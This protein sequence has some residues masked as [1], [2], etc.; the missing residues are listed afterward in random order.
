MTITLKVGSVNYEGWKTANVSRG[1]GYVASDFD[2]T[3]TEKWAD[4]FEIFPIKTG[5]SVSVLVNGHQVMTGH[6]D[7]VAPQY[8]SESHNLSIKGRSKTADLVDCSVTNLSAIKGQTISQVAKTLA[9]PFGLSVTANTNSERSFDEDIQQDET[10]SEVLIELAKME[11]FLIYDSADGGLIISRSGTK[12]S[13]SKLFNGPE[14]SNVLSGGS[15]ESMRDRYSEYT[16][17]GQNKGT[18]TS[19]GTSASEPSAT[20]YDR[21]VPRYRPLVITAD[22]AADT[23]YCKARAEW[24]RSVRIGQSIELNY[25]VQGWNDDAG[26][27]WKMNIL[28]PVQDSFA[29]IDG[30]P[31]NGVFLITEVNYGISESGETTDLKLTLPSAYDPEPQITNN[32]QTDGFI[33]RVKSAGVLAQQLRQTP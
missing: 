10:P 20:V 21:G 12:K 3:V 18:D 9:S 30:T 31:V 28:I 26:D 6:V 25:T 1:I 4:Q 27:L 14:G 24:E 2:L 5:Q 7:D 22:K 16:V 13:R 8:N 33:E 19:F 11:G 29:R 32:D 17:K 15:L 23:S